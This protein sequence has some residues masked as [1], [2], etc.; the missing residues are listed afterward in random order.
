MNRFISASFSE[1]GLSTAVHRVA[2]LVALLG[3][4]P[5]GHAQWLSQ[6]IDLQN[7]W[8]GVFLHVDAS[9]S[10]LNTA[11]GGDPSNPIQEVWRWNPPPLTQ[12]TANPAD[13]V[14]TPEWTA[15]SRVDPASPLQ[16]LTGDTA[17]LV[18]VNSRNGYVWNVTGRPVPPRHSWSISGLNLIG[19]PT[20][21]TNP[22]NFAAFLANARDLES[23]TPEIYRYVGGNLN[24]NNPELLAAPQ[25]PRAPVARGAAFW[26]RAG[27]VFNRYFGPFEVV[28]SGLDGVDFGTSGSSSTFRLRNLSAQALTVTLGLQ[29]SAPPPAGQPI[30]AGAPPLLIRTDLNLT[31][32]TYASTNLPTGGSH[33]WQLAP[34]DQP[35]SEVEVVLGLNRAATTNSPGTLLAGILRFTDSLG[36]TVVHVPVS[37]TVSSSAGLWVGDVA[38]DQVAHYLKSYARDSANVP[39]VGT[40]RAYVVTGIDTS[41]GAVPRTYPLRLIVHNPTVGNATL[42][43][44]VYHGLSP[45]TNPV[46]ANGESALNPGFLQSAR[47]ITAAHLPWS[48]SNTVWRFDGKLGPSAPITTTVAV[49]HEDQVSNPF[50]HS[51]H[52]D[53][54]NLNATFDTL[55]PQGS[56]SYGVERVIRLTAQPPR[57]DFSSLV[58]SGSRFTGQYHELVTLKGLARAG[59]TNDTRQF[60]ARGV[61]TL[62]RV[63]EIPDLTLAP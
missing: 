14:S 37:A 20:V 58:A 9:Q 46:V 40:N 63:S 25:F 19:F 32:L 51:Y 13:P 53:H 6:S 10:T 30:I 42:L 54:D 62:D 35:G 36:H 55:L 22:P 39:I 61:F 26:M 17:Y 16:R 4:A 11:V 28:P 23:V 2:L 31:D 1:S 56:E 5:A 45:S 50:L 38:I 8:N 29:A 33:S 15:W 41:L 49:T 7:G 44:R 18:R 27:T 21:A 43:Q 47:R 34:R 48:P 52:P 60:E 57:N 12:F 24:K 59:G 3:L